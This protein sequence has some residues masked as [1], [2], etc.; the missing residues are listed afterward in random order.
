[1]LI[2]QE[3]WEKIHKKC[4]KFR[5]YYT[6]VLQ[7][8]QMPITWHESWVFSTGLLTWLDDRRVQVAHCNFSAMKKW[9]FE[10]HNRN[11]YLRPKPAK[12]ISNVKSK[13]ATFFK[14]IVILCMT[15]QKNVQQIYL[16]FQKIS[17]LIFQ[18][19]S[20][21]FIFFILNER[22]KLAFFNEFATWTIQDKVCHGTKVLIIVS[23][24]IDKISLLKI[25]SFIKL[26]KSHVSFTSILCCIIWN[27]H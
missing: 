1:M 6:I 26:T 9:P 25:L 18:N 17:W 12:N 16:I 2:S 7:P 3:G 22:K 24:F 27:I 21:Y 15:C 8:F 13:V 4:K 10:F 5:F 14:N 23:C 20:S 19:S 11:M